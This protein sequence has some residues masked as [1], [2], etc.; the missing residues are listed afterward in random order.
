MTGSVGAVAAQK[1]ARLC[2]G[3]GRLREPDIKGLTVPIAGLDFYSAEKQERNPFCSG[4]V[5][6]DNEQR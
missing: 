3:R 6:S 5:E 2:L 4:K 1:G